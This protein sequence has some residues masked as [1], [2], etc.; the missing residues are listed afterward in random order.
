MRA[1]P[2]RP[3]RRWCSRG[4]PDRLGPG[5][6]RKVRLFGVTGLGRVERTLRVHERLAWRL[7]ASRRGGSGETSDF[8]SFQLTR[9]VTQSGCFDIHAVEDSEPEV[10]ERGLARDDEVTSGRKGAIP[11]S[12]E[13]NWEIVV[14]VAVTVR[15]AASD[16]NHAVVEEIAL[17][18]WG[19]F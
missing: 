1:L 18:L 14:V 19:G 3:A 2:S 8:Q 16:G 15:V 4:H 12:G 9:T 10:V 6:L 7:G 17:T 5:R 13:K 11:F